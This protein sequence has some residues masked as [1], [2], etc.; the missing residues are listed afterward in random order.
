MF[1]L[2][3]SK[4]HVRSKRLNKLRERCL[5]RAHLTGGKRAGAGREDLGGLK[6]EELKLR[7]ISGGGDT[8]TTEVAGAVFGAE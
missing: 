1:A 6:K 7:V 4:R 8:L 5:I 2:L 3:H